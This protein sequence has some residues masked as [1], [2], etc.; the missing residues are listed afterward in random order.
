MKS[1]TSDNF[2]LKFSPK[3]EVDIS[4]ESFTF[5]KGSLTTKFHTCI[6][7]SKGK[8]AR[9]TSVG[10]VPPRPFES[11]KV[12]LFATHHGDDGYGDDGYHDKYPCLS[13]FLKHCTATMSPKFAMVRPTFIVRGVDE[14][15]PV[16][17]GY[18]RQIIMDGLRDAGAARI[19]FTED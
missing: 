4:R 19:L 10:E 1:V 2:L 17:H 15:Q 7:L 14:L 8:N 18:Q 13:A 16:L 12:D 9:I 5:K 6:Y 11:F 3:I